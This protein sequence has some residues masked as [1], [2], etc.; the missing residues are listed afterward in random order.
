M[1]ALHCFTH[2]RFRLDLTQVDATSGNKGLSQAH[3]TRDFYREAFHEMK[4]FG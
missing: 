2:E 1:Q 3:G 4:E